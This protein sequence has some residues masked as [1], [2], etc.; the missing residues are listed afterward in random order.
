MTKSCFKLRFSVWVNR[1]G[2][3]KYVKQLLFKQRS[4]YL[5]WKNG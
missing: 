4:A 1:I 2:Y 5:I 3:F